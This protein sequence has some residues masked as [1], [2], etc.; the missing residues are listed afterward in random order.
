MM[1]G[2]L[3]ILLS[4]GGRYMMHC[5]PMWAAA[6]AFAARG[7]VP[8][9]PSR[10]R[11]V[12]LALVPLLPTPAISFFGKLGPQPFTSAM[13]LA[14]MPFQKGPMWEG[15]E[16]NERYGP[17]CD[18]LAAWL[19]EN[20]SPGEVVFTNKEWVA[21]SIALVAD[22]PTDFGAWW[23]CGTDAAKRWNHAWRDEQ[24]SATFVVIK[25]ES[26]V[27]SILRATE[28][29]PPVDELLELGRFW[30]GL[31]HE[32]RFVGPGVE[33]PLATFRALPYAGVAGTVAVGPYW[34]EWRTPPTPAGARISVIE[35]AIPPA[36]RDAY[37]GIR[38]LVSSSKPEPIVLGCVTE[39]GRELRAQITIAAANEEQVVTVPLR[40]MTATDGKPPPQTDRV[41]R[42]YL[43]WAPDGALGER[44]T[45]LR[46]VRLLREEAEDT[47]AT[48]AQ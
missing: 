32:H 28:A 46:T 11:L 36:S 44:K 31:R 39:S 47:G 40:W 12:L 4:Y 1:I 30:I 17:D 27:G 26:D 8:A 29:M 45:W 13:I 14:T 7:V 2:F 21:D 38:L 42:L 16:R 19:H 33:V 9:A 5:L 35:A 48:S 23:E 22:R 6:G 24:P 18:A 15:K 34:L 25:P 43:S 20:T 41:S 3:P 10:L 37:G